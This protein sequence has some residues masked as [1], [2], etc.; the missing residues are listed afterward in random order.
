M[1][2]RDAERHLLHLGFLAAR[3]GRFEV[4]RSIFSA[5]VLSHPDRGAPYVG[6]LIAHLARGHLPEAL[7]CA[8]D[9]LQASRDEDRPDLHALRGV[10]LAAAGRHAESVA[11]LQRAGAHP[12]AQAFAV[13]GDVMERSF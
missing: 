7:A 3:W 9:G 11:A 8:D 2:P 10:V 4:A 12:L 6:L 13:R 1:I 5:L